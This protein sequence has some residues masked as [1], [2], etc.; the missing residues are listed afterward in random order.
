MNLPIFTDANGQRWSIGSEVVARW[1]RETNPG[2]FLEES[3]VG[4][5]HRVF[6]G[7]PEGWQVEVTFGPLLDAHLRPQPFNPSQVE[8]LLGE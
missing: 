7:G 6:A 8:R 2:E 1:W 3:E 4:T 5:V